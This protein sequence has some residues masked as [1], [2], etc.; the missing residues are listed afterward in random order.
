MAAL[1]WI[2][3]LKGGLLSSLLLLDLG[4]MSRELY[5]FPPRLSGKGGRVGGCL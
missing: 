3:T 1:S 2:D 5:D 4:G